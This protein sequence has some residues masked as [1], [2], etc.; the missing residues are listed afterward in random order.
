MRP[1]VARIVHYRLTEQDVSDAFVAHGT[2]GGGHAPGDVLPAVIT[3]VHGD[4]LLVNLHI[5]L[6]G[7]S[8]LWRGRVGYSVETAGCWFWLPRVGD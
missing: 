3:K 6:D 2:N 5:W 1:S 7:P 4:E 8:S